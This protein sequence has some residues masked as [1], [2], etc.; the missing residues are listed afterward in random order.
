MLHTLNSG[1]KLNSKA[2]MKNRTTLDNIKHTH[3][4]VKLNKNKNMRH[5]IPNQIWKVVLVN[6]FERMRLVFLPETLEEAA[7]PISGRR[8]ARTPSRSPIQRWARRTR[9]E[10]AS[11]CSSRARKPSAA[12]RKH[13]QSLQLLDCHVLH[14]SRTHIACFNRLLRHV[15]IGYHPLI[16]FN[17]S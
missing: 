11:T 10:P 5:Q 8:R 14:Y 15:F 17:I 9:P 12:R 4:G 1:V 2:Q 3:D 7:V 6:V 16:C 13:E